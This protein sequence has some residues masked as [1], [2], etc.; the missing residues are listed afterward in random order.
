MFSFLFVLKI[1]VEK[2][3]ARVHEAKQ[4]ELTRAL[5]ELYARKNI[6]FDGSD[7]KAGLSSAGSS[8]PGSSPDS[9]DGENFLGKLIMRVVDNVIISISGVHIRYEEELDDDGNG[10]DDQEIICSSYGIYLKEF[11][12]ASNET[13][14]TEDV[15]KRTGS[16][17]ELS[18]YVIPRDKP[19]QYENT[20]D[21]I[22]KM[23]SLF[24]R[25]VKNE[26]PYN[27]DYVL[28]PTSGRIEVNKTIIIASMHSKNIF[29]FFYPPF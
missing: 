17:V 13:M 23:T 6:N 25:T 18:A 3:K 1:D 2:E 22:R 4:A 26:S 15:I 16:L 7:D 29:F 27:T 19:V 9:N 12:L 8:Q 11:K 28:Y 21:F 5:A 20:E 14:S 10:Q 24:P